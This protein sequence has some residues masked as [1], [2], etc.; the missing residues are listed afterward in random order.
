[1]LP[2]QC[3]RANA[4]PTKSFVCLTCSIQVHIARNCSRV[5]YEESKKD[6]NT[7]SSNDCELCNCSCKTIIA[8]LTYDI[9]GV[10]TDTFSTLK[11]AADLTQIFNFKHN[12]TKKLNY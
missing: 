2:L 11:L 6:R 9:V 5:L 3:L 4:Q 10:R 7:C 12:F 1:M 8:V